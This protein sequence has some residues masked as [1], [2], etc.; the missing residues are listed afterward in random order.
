[1]RKFAVLML[2]V[3]TLNMGCAQSVEKN[4]DT[5]FIDFVKYFKKESKSDIIDFRKT[6][7][8][9]AP[10]LK[11]EALK[12]VYHTEDTTKLYCLW[13]DYSNENEEVRGILG[14][15]LYLPNRCLKIDMGNYFF[16]AYNSYQCANSCPDPNNLR[17]CFLNEEFYV[18]LTLCVVDKGFNLRD[19]MIVCKENDYD[20]FIEGLLNPKN[21]KFFLHN[22]YDK[23]DAR[24]YEVNKKTLEF[25][26]V[27]KGNVGE[28]TSTNDLIKVLEELGWAEL[29]SN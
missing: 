25:E 10:M 4:N 15:N 13:F 2:N 9:K 8:V 5:E 23:H 24:I 14:A 17:D 18:F 29:F 28:E 20:F 3:L 19:S 12:F 6:I 21:G 7:N 1:M 27:E 11:E 16:I 22:T 26:V